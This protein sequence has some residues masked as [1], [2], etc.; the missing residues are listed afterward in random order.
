MAAKSISKIRKA[1]NVARK[2]FYKTLSSLFLTKERENIGVYITEI[3]RRAK[4][5]NEPYHLSTVWRFKKCSAFKFLRD[6]SGQN[7]IFNNCKDWDLP[8]YEF[9]ICEIVKIAVFE[10]LKL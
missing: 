9:R 2:R 3:E 6:F 7:A 8:K 1:E 10:A 5:M 4:W